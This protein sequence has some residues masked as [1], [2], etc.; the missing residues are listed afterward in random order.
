MKKFWIIKVIFLAAVAIIGFGF[1]VMLLWNALIPDLFHGPV[2]GFGQAIGLL[3][4]SKILLKGMGGCGRNHWRH[5]SWRER[6]QQKMDAMSPEERE[7]FR[8]QWRKRCGRFGNWREPGNDE[9][10]SA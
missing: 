9:P 10:A 4:L 6:M 8:E 7:K 3:V 5:H 1:A 2:I